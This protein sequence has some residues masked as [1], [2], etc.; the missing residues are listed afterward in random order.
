MSAAH[1]TAPVPTRLRR[2]RGV[3][4]LVAGTTFALLASL[5]DVTPAAATP[6]N[7]GDPAVISDWNAIAVTTLLADPTKVAQESFLYLGFV[8]AAVY[9][10]VVGIDGR[11]EPYRFHAHASHPASDQAAAAAAAHKILVE[12][13]PYAVANLDARYATSLAAIP[14]GL[15]KTNGIAFGELAATTLIGQRQGDGR[16]A[17]ILFTKAPGPGVWRPTPPAALSMAV[18]WMGFVEPLLIHSGAQF[19][20]TEPPP[21]LTSP[22]YTRDFREVKKLGAAGSTARTPE[23]TTTAMFFSGNATVQYNAAL[24]DQLAVRHLNIVDAARTSAAVDMSLADAI[25][26]IWRAKYVYGFWRPISAIQLANTDGNP[27]TTVDPFWT[28]LLTTPPYPDYVSGYSAVTGAFTDALAEVLGTRHLELTLISTATPGVQRTY[29][30]GRT[31]N[32]DVISA[33]VWLGIHFRFADTEGVEMGQ[34]VA[35]WALDHY[36]QRAKKG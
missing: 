30:S 28:P 27:A 23:Q 25:I 4:K 17:A 26:S 31:L 8:Q 3:R 15:A 11:Y 9:N 12:Y 21:A 32:R 6:S 34:H 7:H 13:S 22:E 18:P 33:R 14:D 2:A 10:A 5:I 24:R 1:F 29:D 35:A 16:N 19:G 20:L 36:F